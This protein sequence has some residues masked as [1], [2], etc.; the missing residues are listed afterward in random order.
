MQKSLL[1]LSFAYSRRWNPRHLEYHFYGIWN[2]IFGHLTDDQ[3][4]LICIPQSLVYYVDS[5]TNTAD[6][7]FG[8]FAEPDAKDVLPDFAVVHVNYSLRQKISA[9]NCDLTYWDAFKVD[10][11]GIPILVEVKQPPGCTLKGRD[12]G[13]ILSSYL[14]TAVTNLENQT[15]HLFADHTCIC[16]KS[17]ILVA[18][19]GEW[20]RWRVAMYEEFQEYSKFD[21]IEGGK[22]EKVVVEDKED[23]D[24]DNRVYVLERA[25]QEDYDSDPLNIE[26]M[27]HIIDIGD[28]EASVVDDIEQAWPPKGAWS[29]NLRLG[30]TASNQRFYLIHKRLS[31]VVLDIKHTHG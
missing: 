27:A 15:F 22:V 19:S 30:M 5:L 21:V 1:A 16:Q 18:C 6:I 12:F 9:S 25:K 28:D 14:N 3:E 8:T 31:D 20:W 7:S 2:R 11:V 4:N 29:I 24:E 13:S 10:Y 17:V 26:L 23:E